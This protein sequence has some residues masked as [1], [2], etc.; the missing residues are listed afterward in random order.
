[1]K[2]PCLRER[3]QLFL[4]NQRINRINAEIQPGLTPGQSTLKVNVE[5]SSPWRA[6]VEFNNFQ[7]PTVGAERGIGTIM[8]LNPL[9]LGDS[10]SLSYGRSEGVD[11]LLNVRYSIPFTPWDTTFTGQYR[12]ND[13]TV[14]EAPFAPLNIESETEVYTLSIRQPIIRTPIQ[15]IAITLTGA[16]LKNS[17][18]LLGIPFAFSP[19]STA[20]GKVNISVLRFA[21]EWVHRLPNQVLAALSRFS[22][23][24]DVLG[25]TTSSVAIPD[26]EFF[27]WLGQIQGARRLVF[28]DMQVIGRMDIQWAA[29]QLFSL[30]QYPIGGRFTVRGYRE[31]TLVRDNAFLFSVETRIP[32]A[33][34]FFGEGT[35]QI[36]PFLDVGRSWNHNR[37]T[38]TPGTL[39]SIGLGV[40]VTLRQSEFFPLPSAQFNMYWGQQLNHVN[41][42]GRNLQ[43]HGIHL[44]M[45]TEVL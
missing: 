40:W 20:Q 12:R 33:A 1:M 32:V 14:V 39:A 5:E 41:D 38:P 22:V 43:D 17:N 45:V 19:G 3:L 15:E 29:D 37:I 26:G 16:H 9:G 34:S 10:F 21:Q 30:E 27:V 42:P 35:V 13:F 25:A 24:L 8:H 31:N 4:Q 18:F 7:S 2:W 11:P 36:A 6:W 44:Q 23:G 28:L